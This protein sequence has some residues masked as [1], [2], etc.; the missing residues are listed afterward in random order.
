MSDKPISERVLE[1]IE[2]TPG[3]SMR[4]KLSHLFALMITGSGVIAAQD[5]GKGSEEKDMHPDPRDTMFG[6]VDAATVLWGGDVLGVE[7][8][9]RV[10]VGK[11][12]IYRA[13]ETKPREYI[14]NA[15]GGGDDP[16]PPTLN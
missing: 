6:F 2:D 8:Q 5:A 9:V 14:I 15:E 4:A 1:I 11:T 7:V 16:Q 3:E 10:D 13:G 12:H